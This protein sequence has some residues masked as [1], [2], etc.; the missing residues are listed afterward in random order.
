[1]K[2][3]LLEWRFLEEY[4]GWSLNQI[5]H[6]SYNYDKLSYIKVVLHKAY[7]YFNQRK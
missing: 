6:K 2:V 3:Y 1:M 5:F 7:A 4:K